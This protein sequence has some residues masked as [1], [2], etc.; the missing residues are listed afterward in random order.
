MTLDEVLEKLGQSR[1]VEI[2]NCGKSAGWHW[3]QIGSK[4]K[5]PE[6]QTLI[7]W[8]DYLQLSD[9]DLGEL[10]RDAHRVRISVMEMLSKDD[11]RRLKTRSALRRDLAREIA[12]ELS[13]DTKSKEKSEKRELERKRRAAAAK[14]KFLEEQEKEQAR[15]LRLEEYRKKL[16]KI[17][18]TNDSF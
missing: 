13:H 3:Y 2:S 15:L 12:E 17:R 7:A 10:V 4:R 14:Q 1:A 9:A 5:V 18:N 16:N 8:A 6:M 11:K